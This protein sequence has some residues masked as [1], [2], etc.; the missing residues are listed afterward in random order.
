MLYLPTVPSMAQ[1]AL[2]VRVRGDV[3]TERRRLDAKLASLARDAVPDIHS[4]DQYLA[5]GIYP[6]RAASWIGFAVGGLALLLTVSGIYGVLSYSVT[7]RTKE[8]GIRVALGATTGTVIGL[9]LR[10]SLR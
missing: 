4:L 10:Q 1:R 7:Q 2:M 6:F 3:E 5:V 8:F 9:V